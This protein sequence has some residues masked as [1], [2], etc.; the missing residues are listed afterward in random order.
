MTNNHLFGFLL[1]VACF[2]LFTAIKK[3]LNNT[4]F[5]NPLVLS[6]ILIIFILLISKVPFDSYM[7]GAG[8]IH[9]FLG[10][11]TVVLALPLY[12]QRKL[13]AKHKFPIIGGILSGVIASLLSITLLCHIFNLEDILERSIIPHSVTNP[14]GIEISKSLGAIQG[15]T[16]ASIVITGIL[17]TIIAPFIY[18][19]FR[20]SNPIAKGLGLGTS[21]HALGTARAV[22]MGETEGAVSGLAIGLAAITTVI[23]VSLLQITG[24]Y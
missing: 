24:W 17:G 18:K 22:D 6:T 15:I 12:R 7:K 11:V 14:I 10:P 23:I 16:V 9:A 8:I 21:A 1:T 20:I 19:L 3:K 2:Y 4:N 13:L 5:I